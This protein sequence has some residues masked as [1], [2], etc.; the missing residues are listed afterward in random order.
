MT[1]P[2][3]IWQP[4]GGVVFF[5]DTTTDETHCLGECGELKLEDEE[6]KTHK[7][8]S[9]V[10]RW[11]KRCAPVAPVRKPRYRRPI[12]RKPPRK[13]TFT[14]E[15]LSPGWFSFF[16]GIDPPVSVQADD[17]ISIDVTP[18][19]TYRCRHC[20]YM[21]AAATIQHVRCNVP[22]AGCG[23]PEGFNAYV[24]ECVE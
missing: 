1:H 15:V 14:A 19:A 12:R 11:R 21:S 17:I 8:G 3:G 13:G 24:P 5:R 23:D 6:G 7:F 20:G 9:P 4:R 10:L 2:D 22:C 16:L 18:A